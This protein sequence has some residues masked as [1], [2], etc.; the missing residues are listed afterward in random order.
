MRNATE[1]ETPFVSQ[2]VCRHVPELAHTIK[3]LTA[4]APVLPP[5]P[6]NGEL[7]DYAEHNAQ[8]DASVAAVDV[9]ALLDAL[10]ALSNTMD[11]LSGFR[12]ALVRMAV[13]PNE[14]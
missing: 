5:F 12:N 4:L 7:A 2:I 13:C 9:D 6:V 3:Q 8:I 10:T 14:R 1:R 11:S